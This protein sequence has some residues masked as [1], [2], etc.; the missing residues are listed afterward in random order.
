[1]LSLIFA[2]EQP[3]SSR[4]LITL[5]RQSSADSKIE[6]LSP[7]ALKEPFYEQN[8]WSSSN[9]SLKKQLNI[10]NYRTFEVM[11]EVLKDPPI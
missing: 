3:S 1:M 4:I 10:L 7:D 11:V 8:S 2:I 9:F 5:V 6:K